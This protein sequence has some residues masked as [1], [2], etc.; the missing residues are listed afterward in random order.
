MT[1][2]RVGP[3]SPPERPSWRPAPWQA[4]DALVELKARCRRVAQH[5]LARALEQ[6]GVFTS[7]DGLVDQDP[8]QDVPHHQERGGG[9]RSYVHLGT[10][11]T[12][13]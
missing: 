2:Y 1:L 3:G 6:A 4:G 13:T 7:S 8:R 5:L 10:G 11:N 12:T 9:L